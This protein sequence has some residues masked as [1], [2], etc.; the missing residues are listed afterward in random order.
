MDTTLSELEIE[1]TN[2]YTTFYPDVDLPLPPLFGIAGI[3]FALAFGLAGNGVIIIQFFRSKALRKAPNLFIINLAVADLGFLL[4]AVPILN[5]MV[6]HEGRRG[7]GT[8]A[9][10]IHAFAV[11]S[12][13]GTSLVNMGLIAF[14]RYVAIVHPAKKIL[15]TW[16]VCGI[17]CICTW[18]YSMLQMVPAFLGW[19]RL[20]WVPQH[21]T[22][23]YDWTYNMAYNIILFM[24]H[25]GIVSAI[26]CFCY[27]QIYKVYRQS[28]QRVTG[29]SSNVKGPS[30]TEISLAI[31]LFVVFVIYNVCWTPFSV[32]ILFIIP[33]GQGEDWLHC[34]VLILTYCNSAINVIVYLYYNKV[35]RAECLYMI[36]VRFQ[37]QLTDI[38]SISGRTTK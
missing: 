4:S 12:T 37:N 21:Y 7:Y 9:C 24:F 35:F 18:I 17:L 29:P 28:R 31:Q 33:K 30:K 22:C 38:P 16:K 8:L 19:G 23:S 20:A 6:A 27:W 25:F 15:L 36:G 14:T 13:G 2:Q 10:V 34:L 1:S 5:N 3:S 26:M 32:V 11:I